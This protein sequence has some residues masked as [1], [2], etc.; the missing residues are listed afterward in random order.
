MATDPSVAT[1]HHH[2]ATTS[3]P[4]RVR[5]A[6]LRFLIIGPLIGMPSEKGDL[7]ARIAELAA[8]SWKHPTTDD[9][10]RFQPERSIRSRANATVR[11]ASHVNA[12]VATCCVVILSSMGYFTICSSAQ[13]LCS[14]ACLLARR[15]QHIVMR[16]VN[17]RYLQT[18]LTNEQDFARPAMLGFFERNSRNRLGGR[19]DWGDMRVW[20]V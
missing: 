12:M 13:R 7:S 16:L 5:W 11:M 4:T 14:R 9:T 18:S 19:W 3:T 6:R 17:P 8:Q 2:E 10:V 1:P 15:V 20:I